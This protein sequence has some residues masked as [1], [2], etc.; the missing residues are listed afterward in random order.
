MRRVSRKSGGSWKVVGTRLEESIYRLAGGKSRVRL[1]T[2]C[3]LSFQ[4]SL[5]GDLLQFFIAPNRSNAT[6]HLVVMAPFRP[7]FFAKIAQLKRGFVGLEPRVLS[8]SISF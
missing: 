3:C 7:Y 1:P 4:K 6:G 2:H 5:R 8:R